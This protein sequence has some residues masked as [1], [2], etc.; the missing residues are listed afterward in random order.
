LPE[1]ATPKTSTT[2]KAL[3]VIIGITNRLNYGLW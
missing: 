2:V 1:M 3:A